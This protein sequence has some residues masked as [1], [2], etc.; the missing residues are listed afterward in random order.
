VHRSR[1]PLLFIF[2]AVAA[3]STHED[4][5]VNAV[6]SQDST[7]LAGVDMETRE[8]PLPEACGAITVAPQPAAAN[9]SLAESL[10]RQ[11]YDAE[12]LGQLDK[13]KSLL[14]RA[15][16]LDGTDKSAAYHLGR[17]SESLGDHALA[18]S[19]Y[20]RIL[21]LAPSSAESAEARERVASLSQREAQ[22][23]A[24]TVT[25]SATP[26]RRA[27]AA[28][29]QRVAT[30]RR[31]A[32][33]HRVATTQRVAR[34]TRAAHERAPSGT[35]IPRTT[36]DRSGNGTYAT[37]TDEGSGERSSM[38][39]DAVGSATTESGGRIMGGVSNGD[40]VPTTR[41]GPSRAQ[42][43]GI[44]AIAGAMIGAATG[45]SVKSTV[46]GAAA[47]GL[48]GTIVVGTGMRP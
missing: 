9:R 1:S 46:I 38:P 27:P 29:T 41:R 40:V 22:V 5:N 30:I 47:G 6:L 20:C 33:T 12:L 13:A 26:V 8:S 16:E 28:T 11:A 48:L 19:A 31:V 3:C 23:A 39:A 7:L 2:A 45:R 42:G 4:S 15:S 43:V 25:P 34:T 10:A 18:V 14:Q 36:V 21:T 17:T 44:G 37:N 32:A 35:R 24:A